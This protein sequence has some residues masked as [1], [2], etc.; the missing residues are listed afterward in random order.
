MASDAYET[1]SPYEAMPIVS[2]VMPVYN[3]E[4]FLRE[5]I[6]SV[7]GQTFTEFELIAVDDCSTDG[8][9]AILADYA[10]R[11]PRMIVITNSDNRKLPG[12]LNAGFAVARGKWFSWT[13]D[14]N[15]LHPNMLEQLL[16]EAARA[17][18]ADVLY[19]D[20]RVIDSEGA[21]RAR[22]AAGPRDRLVVDNVV[23]CS[24]LYRREVDH[25]LGGYDVHL[26]GV[27]DYDFWLRA[28][29]AGFTFRPVDRELYRYRRHSGSLTDTRARRIRALVAQVLPRHIEALPA[30]PLR[31]EA[32]LRLATRDPY[33]MRLSAVAQAMRDDPGTV[34]RN[35]R[36]IAA[37][38]K[39]SLKAR[40]G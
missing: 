23:G 3:G 6:E 10:A 33:T 39:A 30:S 18:E 32:L 12:S 31:A 24:F 4:R 36:D 20:Y 26:F 25:A 1:T 37:W 19:S 40:L 5:A 21:P 38:L 14:D 35:W 29:Q 15:V 7:L 17:P 27:E 2:I 16:A 28:A 8:T 13:S 22:I 11:D 9:P 34:V